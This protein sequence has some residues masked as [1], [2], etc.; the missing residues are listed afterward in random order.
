MGTAASPKITP[1]VHRRKMSPRQRWLHDPETLRVHRVLFRVHLWL[2]MLAALYVAAMSLSGSMLVFRD[3]LES[4]AAPDSA[5][6]RAIEWI[7]N[8]HENL[9]SGDV[10]RRLTGIGAI[11]FLLI[12]VTGAVIWWPGIAH[13]RRSLTIDWRS[14]PARLN[15]DLH[16]A[17]GAL[18]FLFLSVWGLS[19]IYFAFPELSYPL[20]DADPS[21]TSKFFR[22]ANAALGWFTNLHFGRFD[23][24][25]ETLWTLIGL[26]PAVL[27]FT[28]IFMC[29]HRI[30][31]RKGAPLPDK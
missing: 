7:V 14:S 8:F 17:L 4:S 16:N 24:V 5:R 9:L 19:G 13:W 10:G 25:T 15:W 30:F 29:C 3:R 28:G 18:A 11:A 23:W 26:I 12:C 22:F 21:N 20:V 27:V 1:V 31:I 2:G 6:Y